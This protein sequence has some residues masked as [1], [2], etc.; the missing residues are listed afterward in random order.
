MSKMNEGINELPIE[1]REKCTDEFI[2]LGILAMANKHGHELQRMQIMKILQK[3]KQKA[4]DDLNLEAYHQEFYKAKH[5][6]YT[7]EVYCQLTNLKRSDFIN[8]I[9]SEPLEK[10]S[11]TE[12]G[13]KIFEQTKLGTSSENK[14]LSFIKNIL[15]K[16]VISE[17]HKT[18]EQLKEEN[19][20]R[21]IQLKGKE[22]AIDDLK[23]GVI[24]T[25]N[26]NNGDSFIFNSR[27]SI[28]WSLYRKIAIRKTDEIIPDDEIPNTQKEIYK[29]LDL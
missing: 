6:E 18:S 16:V 27:S 13:S 4:Q 26:I 9:G 15:E 24:T 5:G 10:Y 21:K 23:I 17:A 11:S 19:H 25:P 3:F 28:D 20:K 1:E 2:L 7:S 8:S 12:L 29:L 14:K 22:Y